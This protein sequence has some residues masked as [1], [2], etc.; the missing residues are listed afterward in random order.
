M[1]YFKENIES[2]LKN[3]DVNFEAGLKDFDVKER[4]EKY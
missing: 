3:L 4:N 1:K 2:V